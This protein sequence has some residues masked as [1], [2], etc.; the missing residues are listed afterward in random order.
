MEIY[1]QLKAQSSHNYLVVK[2]LIKTNIKRY[3]AYKLF[4][5]ENLK[6]QK[7]KLPLHEAYP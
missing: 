2:W 5:Y 3:D 7:R 6:E 4:L 1:G